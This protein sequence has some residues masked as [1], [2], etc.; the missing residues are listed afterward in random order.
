MIPIF[1]IITATYT[2]LLG[3]LGAALTINVIRNR[4]KHNVD[5][6]DGGLPPMTKAI[7]AHGNFAE[8]TPLAVVL[9]AFVEALGYRAPVVYGLAAVFLFARLSSAYGLLNSLSQLST[10]R[11]AGAGLTNLVTA[12]SSLLILYTVISAMK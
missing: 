7:R 4:T 2:A 5:I 3:L 11:R 12:L 9:I 6:G 1:P 10:P 8:Q